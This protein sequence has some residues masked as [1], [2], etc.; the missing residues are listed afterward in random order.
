MGCYI[1]PKNMSKEDWLVEHAVSVQGP[2]DVELPPNHAL[3]CWVHNGLFSAAAVVYD[4]REI[5]AFTQPS[6]HRPKQWF[7]ADR[8]DLYKVSDLKNYER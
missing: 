2:N 3:I 7:V 8:E 1:N 4:E 5:D 6:D